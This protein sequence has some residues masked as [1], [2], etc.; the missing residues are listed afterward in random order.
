MKTITLTRNKIA[1]VDD[2]DYEYLS[3]WNWFFD[4]KYAIRHEVLG[5]RTNKRVVWMHHLIANVSSD[6]QVDHINNDMLDNRRENLRPA[7]HQQN[8]FNRRK[9]K[10][11]QS[12]YKGVTLD[13]KNRIRRW[14]ARI[15]LNKKQIGLG[16]FATQEEAAIA[17]NE[18]AK[19]LFGEYARLN[20]VS[21]A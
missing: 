9:V 11:G 15:T 21:L 16:Y 8:M 6:M 13:G 5:P 14:R 12:K 17:Y 10:T 7:T 18:K 20:D 3:Q 19:E 4:G 1:I 2:A